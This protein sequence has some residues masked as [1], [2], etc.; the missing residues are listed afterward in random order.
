MKVSCTLTSWLLALPATVQSF[1][2]IPPAVLTRSTGAG[3][4]LA[5]PPLK[6]GASFYDEGLFE[7]EEEEMIPIAK[8]YLRAKYRQVSQASGRDVCNEEDA[9]EILRSVLPPVTPEELEEEVNKMMQVVDVK[10]GIDQ[11]DFVTAMVQNDYWQE[12]GSLTVK[13]LIYFDALHSYYR[14]GSSLLNND[15]YET[16]KDNLTWEGSSVATMK[17]DEALFVTAV[18]SSKRGT[19][20]LNDQEYMD[21]KTTLK[22]EKSWVTAREQDAMEKLGLNTFMGYLHRAL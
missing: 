11:E 17:A 20:I 7:E 22:K 12:A 15:D 13:E 19:P 16:L 3:A 1:A 5:C 9:R 4:T 21:L 2:V 14:T 18:A 8:N 10:D 6:G